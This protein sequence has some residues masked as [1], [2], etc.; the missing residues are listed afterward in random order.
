MA[1]TQAIF[2]AVT[3]MQATTSSVQASLEQQL[4]VVNASQTAQSA[5]QSQQIAALQ[6]EVASIGAV[7][8]TNVTCPQYP[9]LASGVVLGHGVYV[10][11]LF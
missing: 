5:V 11:Q 6:T 2:N 7:I 4:Q 1:T 3:Q 8:M 10:A 9:A